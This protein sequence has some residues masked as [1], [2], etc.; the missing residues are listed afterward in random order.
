MTDRGASS[1]Q[2]ASPAVIVAASSRWPG[3]GDRHRAP[4]PS[5]GRDRRL[6]AN[7]PICGVFGI[8]YRGP[9]HRDA[10]R[11]GM[12][13]REPAAPSDGGTPVAASSPPRP[14]P[15]PEV[16][17]LPAAPRRYWPLI[18]PGII[19]AG[20]GLASG[21][22]ILFPYIASQVGLVFVWAALVGLLTQFVLNMEIEHY[23]LAT[24]ET[25]LTGFSRYWRHWGL[26]FAVLTY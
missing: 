6:P 5:T 24:G 20:V 11:I 7:V 26:V 21:E 8:A 15:R 10:G 19:A 25:A 4:A 13:A 1:R 16:R 3:I 17:D 2:I 9:D 23:T 12:A 18:G 22:F 14:L